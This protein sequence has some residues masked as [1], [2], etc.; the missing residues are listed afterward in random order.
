MKQPRAVGSGSGTE[1]GLAEF[2]NLLRGSAR[3]RNA[4]RTFL[5]K[6]RPSDYA[7]A[8]RWLA[9]TPFRGKKLA[10]TALPRSYPEVFDGEAL[11]PLGLDQ[12]AAW[13]VALA[14]VNRGIVQQHFEIYDRLSASFLEEEYSQAA[15]LLDASESLCGHSVWTLQLRIALTQLTHGFEAQKQFTRNLTEQA[16]DG[17]LVGYIAHYTS[18]RNESAVTTRYFK[19]EYLRHLSVN[20][21]SRELETCVRY[22]LLNEIPATA[23]GI[24]DLFSIEARLSL[25]DHLEAL[26][27]VAAVVSVGDH[28]D[29]PPSW[30]SSLRQLADEIPNPRLLSIGFPATAEPSFLASLGRVDLMP[31]DCFLRGEYRVAAA[32]SMTLARNVRG[33]HIDYDELAACALAAGPDQIEEPIRRVPKA[34]VATISKGDQGPDEYAAIRKIE[35]N[36]PFPWAFKALQA[37]IREVADAPSFDAFFLHNSYTTPP[38]TLN[39]FHA[40]T[41]GT[42][43]ALRYL[44]GCRDTYGESL[45]VQYVISLMTDGDPPPDLAPE[46]LLL[47][48]ADSA[49]RRKDYAHAAKASAELEAC[50]NSY[51]RQKAVRVRATSL[52]RA[53]H[54]EEC[55]HYITAVFVSDRNLFVILPIEEVVASTSEEIRLSI[56]ESLSVPLLYDMYSRF[57]NKKHETTRRFAYEDFLDR[58]GALR[59]SE[60]VGRNYS[61]P[62]GLLVYFLRYICVPEIMDVSPVFERSKDVEDER[63]AVCNILADLDPEH[64][65]LYQ[66][67]IR[68]LL[69]RHS[70]QKGIRQVENSK[71]FVDEG[72]VRQAVLSKYRETYNRLKA[73]GPYGAQELSEVDRA[74]TKATSGDTNDL[75]SLQVEKNEKNEI[76]AALMAGIRDEYVLGPDHGL[77]G[78]LSVRIRHGTFGAQLRSP[79]EASHLATQKD[80]DT[81]IYKS[82]EYWAIRVLTTSDDVRESVGL[83]LADL[84][85]RFDE[86]TADLVRNWIQIARDS[87]SLGRFNFILGSTHL[88]LAAALIGDRDSLEAF[89]DD[90]FGLLRGM[91]SRNLENIRLLLSHDVMNDIDNILVSTHDACV[92]M[93]GGDEV[94]DLLAAIQATR[95]DM[96]RVTTKIADW[97]KLPST[98]STLPF[99]MDS[100]IS[101]AVEL[102]RSMYRREDFQPSI[103]VSDQ[104]LYKGVL[105]PAFVDLFMIMF[106]NI[107]KHSGT[108]HAPRTEV[109]VTRFERDLQITVENDVSATV[110]TPQA[111][112]NLGNIRQ[113][114]A[115]GGYMRSVGKE[116]G[117]GFFKMKKI[118][119]HDLAGSA[120]LAFNFTDRGRFS[121]AIEMPVKDMAE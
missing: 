28:R 101:I 13:S 117:T 82:N 83:A 106:E 3:P 10:I 74:L 102:V 27:S 41:F 31:F 84:S 91:L 20:K 37:A 112:E 72:G 55:I 64:K 88:R 56:A 18:F 19:D 110:R 81:G 54:I 111:D 38:A 33:A 86:L 121:V 105:L 4:F 48:R 99:S 92:S 47:A 8:V 17:A 68:D 11:P 100:A 115:G 5:P 118:I 6:L 65:D 7:A 94:R 25:I 1:L 80:K 46:I 35:S 22:H 21:L 109:A 36:T 53:G 103:Q 76:L 96:R 63:I 87:S 40:Y 67:E 108:P 116:G 107:I 95:A 98:T 16:G 51:F 90:I 85:R 114:I 26:L 60:L 59:P 69:I 50:Q 32:S 97:F 89:V 43:A 29:Q 93:A 119:T 52:L 2:K 120:M 71:I 62:R 42:D 15:E 58:H 24:V 34:L 73:F 104:A 45:S 113:A 77:D 14:L 23:R 12:W 70:I 44:E 9:G 75:L 49:L 79:L 57:V 66:G 61:F 39:P 78:Y 30:L